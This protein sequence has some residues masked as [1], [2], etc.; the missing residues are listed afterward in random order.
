MTELAA[1]GIVRLRKRQWFGNTTSRIGSLAHDVMHGM[2]EKGKET[3]EELVPRV[4][5]SGH[6]LASLQMC[7]IC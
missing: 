3:Y 1:S 6:G 2:S 5:Q 7:E 4:L